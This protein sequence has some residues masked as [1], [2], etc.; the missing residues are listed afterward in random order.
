MTALFL[1]MPLFGHS[2]MHAVQ[3]TCIAVYPIGKKGQE[4]KK[5]GEDLSE[6]TEY[7][8]TV[9]YTHLTLPTT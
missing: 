7:A 8:V 3:G 1:E 2:V 5:E 4:E 9:S 6:T